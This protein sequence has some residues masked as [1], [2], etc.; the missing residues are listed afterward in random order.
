[1]FGHE[2]PLSNCCL[3]KG[4]RPTSPTW[5][6]K[7]MHVQLSALCGIGLIPWRISMRMSSE[8]DFGC[9]SR[10][11]FFSRKDWKRTCRELAT[12][13]N[14][15]YLCCKCWSPFAFLLMALFTELDEISLTSA[16]HRFF[17]KMTSICNYLSHQYFLMKM[18]S[19]TL[20]QTTWTLLV[21][22]WLI[23]LE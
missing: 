6:W 14:Q 13:G 11:G 16:R 4:S 12:E 17:A 3:T 23:L 20:I 15:S 21:N 5:N 10:R 2:P 8:T 22:M 18:R 1:M 9:V 19:I 7:R